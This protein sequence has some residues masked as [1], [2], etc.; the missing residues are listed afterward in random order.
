MPKVSVIIPFY[1]GKEF[2]A[3]A[4]NSVLRQTYTS[5]EIIV[6]DDGSTDD[7][8][9]ALEQFDGKIRYFYQQNQG[10]SNARNKA[11]KE[12]KG[13]YI[14]LLDQDDI[15]Y[16]RRLEKQ[17]KVMD[18]NSDISIVYSDCHY[19]NEKNEI[20]SQAFEVQKARSG[21]IFKDLIIKNFIPIPTV[22]LRK[23]AVDEVGLFDKRYSFAEEY[24]LFLRI[25]RIYH[26]SYIDE[27]LAGYRIH[28]KNLSKNTEKS[29]KED[30]MLKEEIIK[31][32]PNDTAPVLSRIEREIAELYY[33]LGRTYQKS[34]KYN[35]AKENLLKSIK[36]RKFNYRQYLYYI[37]TIILGLVPQNSE[38]T[39]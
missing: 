31:N 9:K 24:Y 34:K 5:Y 39:K 7:S 12:A 23:R 18:E 15:W 32:Y 17:V 14:A 8:K 3:Q 2:I 4:V 26:V 13:E 27:P 36:I 6:V 11:V 21:R 29:L 28:G 19:I 16:P 10:I 33:G 22:L 1:N 37:L 30:I 25:A 20:L 38:V 35:L